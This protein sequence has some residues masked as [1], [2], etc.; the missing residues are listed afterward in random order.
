M[1]AVRSVVSP[2]KRVPTSPTPR[3]ATQA[4]TALSRATSSA[5]WSHCATFVHAPLPLF[6]PSSDVIDTK[7]LVSDAP[8]Q[9]QS[10][11]AK[12]ARPKSPTRPIPTDGSA[13]A[14]PSSLVRSLPSSRG[15]TCRAEPGFPTPIPSSV[16]LLWCVRAF[17]SDSARGS[18]LGALMPTSAEPERD[19]FETQ[20]YGN[21]PW[22]GV[23]RLN[24]V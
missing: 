15:H 13:P 7:R 4:C 17:D 20:P 9:R 22:D 11:D 10:S 23:H 3:P 14:L 18:R 2:S 24:W 16:P 21:E 19:Q 12:A 8:T 1:P 5:G 6:G